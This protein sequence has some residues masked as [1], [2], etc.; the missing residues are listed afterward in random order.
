MHNLNYKLK[1]EIESIED[2]DIKTLVSYLLTQKL[3]YDLDELPYA[4][5]SKYQKYNP[6]GSV[7][8]IVDHTVKAIRLLNGLLRHPSLK[9]LPTRDKSIMQ[10]A[11]LVAN[12]YR[13][14]TN[15][16]PNKYT[17][18]EYP[19]LVVA[20]NDPV[21]EE[22]WKDVFSRICKVASTIK[23]SWNTGY[24]EDD[25][26]LPLPENAPQYYVHL[27]DYLANSVY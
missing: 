5:T 4:S 20:A 2:E 22:N 24:K 23:G 6:D 3:A 21:I 19:L 18:H 8:S 15:S 27:C 11:I 7:E 1:A 17:V 13:Y 10:G 26:V 25:V 9:G 16:K 12:M 14:G